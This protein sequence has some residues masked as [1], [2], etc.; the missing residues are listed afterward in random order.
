LKR[1]SNCRTGGTESRAKLK[2]CP[3]DSSEWTS[4]LPGEHTRQ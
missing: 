4:E 2:T 1:T 3:H